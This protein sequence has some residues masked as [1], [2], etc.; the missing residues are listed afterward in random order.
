MAA[1]HTP[2][3]M[4]MTAGASGGRKLITFPVL[5]LRKFRSEGRITS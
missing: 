1:A 3:A 2:T 5:P 4:P